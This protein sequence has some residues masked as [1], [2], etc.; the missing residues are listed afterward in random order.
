MQNRANAMAE[1]RALLRARSPLYA[2]ADHVVDTSTLGVDASVNAIV[3]A[4]SPAR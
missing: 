4:V 2:Q 1:L 3:D